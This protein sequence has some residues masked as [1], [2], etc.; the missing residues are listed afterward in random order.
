VI[1]NLQKE[2]YFNV[3]CRYCLAERKV[4]MANFTIKHKQQYDYTCYSCGRI[5]EI[6]IRINERISTSGA[7]FLMAFALI[8]GAVIVLVVLNVR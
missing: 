4:F 7:I 1:D 8:I 3:V 5:N 2:L 6:T